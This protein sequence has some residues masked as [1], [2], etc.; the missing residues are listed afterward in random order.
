[1]SLLVREKGFYK[2]FFSLYVSIALQALITFVVNF[3]DNIMIGMY[4][5][6]SMSGV[7]LVNMIQYLLMQ[8][9]N[10]IAAG[11]VVLSAQY[12]GKGETAPIRRI[13]A[14][15][16][17]F[18]MLTGAIFTFVT[19]RYPAECLSLLTNDPEIIGQGVEYLTY[20]CLTYLVF[21]FSNTLILSFRSVESTK[22]APVA[23]L[24]SLVV[25]V[26]L[27]YFFIFGN[28]G[29]P[30]MGAR[31]AGLATLIARLAELIVVVIYVKF[32]DKKLRIKFLDWLKPDWGYLGA[33]LRIS[34][35]VILAGASWGI[36]VFLQTSILGHVGAT[37]VAANSISTTMFQISTIFYRGTSGASSI[38][39][40]KTIGAGQTDKIKP[41]TRTIQLIFLA[42]GILSALIIMLLR[43]FVIDFYTLTPEARELTRDFMLILAI[44]VIGTSYEY[45]VVVGIIQSGGDTKYGLVVDTVFM[46]LLT[47]PLAYLSAFVFHWPAEIT[48]IFLN[49]DQILKC[50]PNGIKVNRY[51]W[52]RVLT[53]EA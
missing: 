29:C 3:A 44:A 42:F 5:Q 53:R 48:Y 41:Y 16:M 47:L 2:W 22:V 43:S 26:I 27:N 33:Y 32:S 52:I 8:L 30:E 50:L 13:I 45:P 12:W 37:A 49:C 14:L 4:D 21:T 18:A 1:M 7:S 6:S 38:I 46:F 25:N 40:G 19:W 31:G 35:P 39:I 23:A 17:K 36:G 34:I 20:I 11:V 24:C 51:K 9:S 28:F 10:G 15:G